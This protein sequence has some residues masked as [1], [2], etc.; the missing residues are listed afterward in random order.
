[1]VLKF[2]LNRWLK[3]DALSSLTI[4]YSIIQCIDED[5]KTFFHP[6]KV[7]RRETLDKMMFVVMACSKR[8]LFRGFFVDRER[9]RGCDISFEIYVK[10]FGVKKDHWTNNVTILS[11]NGIS[12]KEIWKYFI[13]YF[14]VHI[15]HLYYTH[16]TFF[17]HLNS[18]NLN[19]S[20]I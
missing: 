11:K 13:V 16:N 3:S 20:I 5:C 15:G 7:F 18:I 9:K 19:S 2:K 4:L 14:I 8:Y 10:C 6:M 12:L 1:M 17:S